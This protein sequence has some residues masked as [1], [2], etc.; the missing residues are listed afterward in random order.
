MDKKVNVAVL[1]S[2]GGTNLQ[3]LIDK[4]QTGEISGAQIVRVIA[5]EKTLLL[6]KEQQ[7]PVLK[8][9]WQRASR[10]FLQNSTMQKRT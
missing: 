10:R 3:A 9:L 4:A 5:A 7:K 1:V 2:G 8:A 6:L